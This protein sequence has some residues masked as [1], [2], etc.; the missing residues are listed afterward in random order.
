MTTNGWIVFPWANS[1]LLPDPLKTFTTPVPLHHRFNNIIPWRIFLLV[2][3]T[4]FAIL[5][6][7]ALWSRTLRYDTRVKTDT[8]SIG[9]TAHGRDESGIHSAH[10]WPQDRLPSFPVAS[11][12]KRFD[13]ACPPV[14][15]LI[16]RHRLRLRWVLINFFR[17]R[18]ITDVGKAVIP[19]AI[20]RAAALTSARRVNSEQT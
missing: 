16:S 17:T 9:R 12:L 18:K 6:C 20:T 10:A 15:R 19:S 8:M 7:W 1:P 11:C 14:R 5:C 3:I 2:L 4:V 13:R